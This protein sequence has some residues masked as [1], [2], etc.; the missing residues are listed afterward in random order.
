[1]RFVPPLIVTTQ[2]I[3]RLIDCLDDVLTDLVRGERTAAR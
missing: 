2:E 1:L 3:D